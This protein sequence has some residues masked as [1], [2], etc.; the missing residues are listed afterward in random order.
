MIKHITTIL[1]FKEQ[2]EK[3]GWT[4]LLL[5][6]FMCEGLKSNNKKSFR[7]KGLL[8]KHTI[9]QVAV[10]PMGDG[11]FILP[12]NAAIRKA[13]G[14]KKGEKIT[15]QLTLDESEIAVS[16]DLLL[17]L[18]DEP[19]A[20]TFYKSLPKGEQNYFSKWI[21][22]AKTHSTKAKRITQAIQ[23]FLNGYK[24]GVM[25]RSLKSKSDL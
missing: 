2:D 5:P 8:D 25:M 24:F 4:Y 11:T 10:M 15:I 19:A 3:S 16:Q 14:K 18:A 13:T 23:G 6:H 20:L 7:V 21:D 1:Q 17:C 9:K 12:L 22:S